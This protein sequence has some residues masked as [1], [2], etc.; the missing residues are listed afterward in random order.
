MHYIANIVYDRADED[1][2]KRAVGLMRELIAT[3]AAEGYGEYR[4][5]LIFADQ[6]S[7][8]YGW[9]NQALRRFNETIKDALDPNGIMAPGRAGIWPKRF[10][11]KGWEI[12]HGDVRQTSAPEAY[13]SKL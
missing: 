1:E 8:T 7:Q 9:N 11:G 12:L 6:V 4:T 3:A 5:H 13:M 2:K 10:R